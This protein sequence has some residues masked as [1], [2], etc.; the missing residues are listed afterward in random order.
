MTY[1]AVVVLLAQAASIPPMP[2]LFPRLV[3]QIVLLGLRDQNLRLL[4]H[5]LRKAVTTLEELVPTARRVLGGTHPDVAG[6]E[7]SLGCARAALCA[8][9]E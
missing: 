6:I 4:R 3:A 9:E 8:R 1:D 7:T 2:P 5:D